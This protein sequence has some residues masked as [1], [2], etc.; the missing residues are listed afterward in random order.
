LR[1]NGHRRGSFGS[2]VGKGMSGKFSRPMITRT[3]PDWA[4]N[5]MRIDLRAFAKNKY[6]RDRKN[7]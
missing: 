4:M 2:L 5:S 1:P 7:R 6:Q 3:T